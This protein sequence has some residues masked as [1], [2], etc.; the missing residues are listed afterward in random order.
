MR[1]FVSFI[2]GLSTNVLV[3]LWCVSGVTLCMLALVA[4]CHHFDVIPLA[5][6][7]V[8]MGELVA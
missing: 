8:R 5:P 7:H 3:V 1:E 4:P 6:P 2:N